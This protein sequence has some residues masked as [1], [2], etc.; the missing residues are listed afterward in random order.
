MDSD[1]FM[2]CKKATCRRCNLFTSI[3]VYAVYVLLHDNDSKDMEFCLLITTVYQ[4]LQ[5]GNGGYEKR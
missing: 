3:T 4:I 2:Q 1:T 5:C